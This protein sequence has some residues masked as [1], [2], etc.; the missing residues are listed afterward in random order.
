MSNNLVLRTEYC[1]LEMLQSDGV[2]DIQI[3]PCADDRSRKVRC[4]GA[5]IKQFARATSSTGGSQLS[6]NFTQF[7]VTDNETH[8]HTQ[9]RRTT[10]AH[11]I[12]IQ[13]TTDREAT[14]EHAHRNM[15]M[16]TKRATSD[17][18]QLR[19]EEIRRAPSTRTDCG[20]R[21]NA[22]SIITPP[23]TDDA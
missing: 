9:Y 14:T 12:C 19:T 18:A 13:Q 21:V 8:A 22:A 20:S 15:D 16:T 4:Y 6:H 7:H 11:R 17:R 10:G 5:R 23:P 2:E 3:K 1:V